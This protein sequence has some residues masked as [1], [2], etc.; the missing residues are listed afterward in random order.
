MSYLEADIHIICWIRQVQTLADISN[1]NK[2]YTYSHPIIE[3]LQRILDMRLHFAR[4]TK[5]SSRN[6]FFEPE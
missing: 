4:L 2:K 3:I 1:I 6:Y 5:L